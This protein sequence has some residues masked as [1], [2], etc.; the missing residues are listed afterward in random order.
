MIS[1]SILVCG[2]MCIL[3]AAAFAQKW[4]APQAPAFPQGD[5]YI[6]IPKAALAPTSTS[7]YSAVFDATRFPLNRKDLVPALFAVGGLYNDFAVG[8]TPNENAHVVVVFHGAA[9]D[10]ILDNAH[11]KQMYGVDNPNLPVLAKMK[12][13]GIE[14]YVCGQFLAAS[15]IDPATISK[16][17]TVAADATLVLIGYQN[18][19]YALMSF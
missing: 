17:V 4:P 10:G 8:G 11:Y 15:K 9:T 18:K 3:A 2:A 19:G 1:R 13:M 14:L 7:T 12:K 6:A 5:T 16:D